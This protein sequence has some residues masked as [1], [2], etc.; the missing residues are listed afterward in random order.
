M[1]KILSIFL[2]ALM[3]TQE[4]SA[5]IKQV[6]RRIALTIIGGT[7]TLYQDNEAIT[8]QLIVSNPTSDPDFQIDLVANFVGI[9]YND[10]MNTGGEIAFGDFEGD[11]MLEF[12]D[13]IAKKNIK[14]VGLNF[15]GTLTYSIYGLNTEICSEAEFLEA[16][17]QSYIIYTI[18]KHQI[19]LL[20][21][22][23][24]LLMKATGS[25]VENGQLTGIEKDDQ[26]EE[27]TY[28]PN[29]KLHETYTQLNTDTFTYYGE[30]KPPITRKELD[31]IDFDSNLPDPI[32]VDE[33]KLKSE[34]KT[35]SKII[36]SM[37][38]FL[39]SYDS[40][41]VKNNLPV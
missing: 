33:R 31:V 9:S 41:N 29:V 25:I 2:L 32:H 5:M 3:I 18:G 7:M 36:K 20:V 27:V 26:I 19:R 34:R 13:E 16:L 21:T 4:S 12:V 17:S 1:K 23:Y 8:S 39:N 22:N 14:N 10:E 30:E 28:I 40:R 6:T 15:D 38:E 37:G 35:L 11:A 24:K